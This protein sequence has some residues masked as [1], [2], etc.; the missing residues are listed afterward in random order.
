MT[1][2]GPAPD[3]AGDLRRRLVHWLA[4]SLILCL[5][6][7]IR[8]A[9]FRNSEPR[10]DASYYAFC[11]RSV[12]SATH[13]LP[14]KTVSDSVLEAL[15][16]DEHSLAYA[17]GRPAFSSPQW[18]FMQIPFLMECVLL[19]I[20]KYSYAHM[21]GLSILG[22][23][24]VLPALAL[25]SLRCGQGHVM[26]GLIATVFCGTSAYAALYSPWGVH[27]WGVFALV[28]AVAFAAPLMADGPD[29]RQTGSRRAAL[30][31]VATLLAAY[32]HFTNPI[33][34]PLAMTLAVCVVPG[35]NVPQKARVL[36]VFAGVV[37]DGIA[38]PVLLSIILNKTWL[39]FG[40]YTNVSNSP[41]TY[42]SGVMVRAAKWLV[43]GTQLFSLPGMVLGLA[44]LLLMAV[45]TR[46]RLPFCVAFAHFLCFCFIPGFIWNGSHT[47]LRTYNYLIPFLALG[48]AWLTVRVTKTALAGLAARLLQGG[49]IACI[50]WHLVMQIPISGYGRWASR[51]V[52]DFVDYFLQGQGSLRPIV[53]E[54]ERRVGA[55]T[56]IF[57]GT[58]EEYVYL[59]LANRF[60][61]VVLLPITALLDRKRRG[62]PLRTSIQGETEYVVGSDG[63]QLPLSKERVT[64]AFKALGRTVRG[65]ELLEVFPSSVPVYGR[66]YL[67]RV[68]LL[69]MI[70]DNGG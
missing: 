16:S 15:A 6:F 27:N 69:P 29:W 39:T 67:Y 2:K 58:S 50:A 20:C 61:G 56:V 13:V 51:H 41:T 35:L 22:S 36:V 7:G 55:G 31:G 32:S 10:I 34:A 25:L 68:A 12:A 19:L 4:L 66:F 65:V 3:A 23:V 57:W 46:Y 45:K 48:M 37:F 40:I 64:E 54:M 62:E 63:N 11:V 24:A 30:I 44:G 38:P 1:P 60:S 47:Y 9:A 14:Q 26:N 8:Y 18:I 49:V 43:L 33:L 70:P 59:S 42:L 53:H 17:L 5:V 52:P 21:V 28:A